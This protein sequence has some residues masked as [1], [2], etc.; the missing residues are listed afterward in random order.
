MKT[1]LISGV[2]RGIGRQLMHDFLRQHNYVI[3]LVRNQDDV[4]KLSTYYSDLGFHNFRV[5]HCDLTN[6]ESLYYFGENIISITDKIDVLVCNAGV[7]IGSGMI[8]D[9][10]I[11]EAKY[12]F[13]INFW[14]AWRLYQTVDEL[15]V[16][17][18]R[19][20]NISS[21]LGLK[22]KLEE[23]GLPGYKLSKWA[24]NGL[25]IQ[26]S[27][28]LKNRG[29]IV[30]AVC[31]GWTQTDMGGAKAPY[32]LQYTSQNL[33]DLCFQDNISTGSFYENGRVVDW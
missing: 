33:I 19:V 7:G 17:G 8:S 16:E 10:S 1:I 29:I 14:G 31:P 22:S 4:S 5:I 24:L 32:T 28:E 20:V 15:L 6:D 3:G 25:T 12:F 27:S 2:S 9:C 11:L 30:F 21:N 23:G 13:D 26:L 18:S